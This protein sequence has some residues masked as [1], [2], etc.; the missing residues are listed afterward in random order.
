[1]KSL[2]TQEGTINALKVNTC[3]TEK[4][5]DDELAAL[6]EK[7]KA[8]KMRSDEGEDLKDMAASTI[9]LCLVNNSLRRVLGL[10]NPVDI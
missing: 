2:L 3:R 10:T 4:I 8:E 1:M 5:T 6:R 9:L 7:D